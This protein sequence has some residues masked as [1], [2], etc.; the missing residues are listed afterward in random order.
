MPI[1]RV[2]G[3]GTQIT[4]QLFEHTG[5]QLAFELSTAVEYVSSGC[6]LHDRVISDSIPHTGLFERSFV[7]GHCVLI[8]ERTRM[9]GGMLVGSS[10][11]GDALG[12]LGLHEFG[13]KAHVLVLV[14]DPTDRGL[15]QQ[16][17]MRIRL[18][19]GLV[20]LLL[21]VVIEQTQSLHRSLIVVVP[22][23][24]YIIASAAH[25][26][27]RARLG[28]VCHDFQFLDSRLSS[29]SCSGSSSGCGGGRRDG[30]VRRSS[31]AED[32]FALSTPT[33]FRVGV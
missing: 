33:G 9:V 14:H 13:Q 1:L 5:L 25:S 8:H 24:Y 18:G 4:F 31:S 22:M 19:V 28:K 29:S 3:G 27:S 23:H 6:P 12:L 10:M 16:I 20:L 2:D 15:P 17:L 32:I 7:A 30:D 26:E 11:L 21:V